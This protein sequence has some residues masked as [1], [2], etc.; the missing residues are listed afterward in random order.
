[1]LFSSGVTLLYH[2]DSQ[3]YRD[4][5]SSTHLLIV[6]HQQLTAYEPRAICGKHCWHP[7]S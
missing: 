3:V 6:T 5:T 1:M 7:G 4:F 2:R